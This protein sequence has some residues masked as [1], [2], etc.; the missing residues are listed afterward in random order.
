MV[1]RGCA[2]SPSEVERH[3]KLDPLAPVMVDYNSSNRTQLQE[4]NATRIGFLATNGHAETGSFRLCSLPRN[5]A[6]CYLRTVTARLRFSFVLPR[7]GLYG[8]ASDL[9]PGGIG[10]LRATTYS[11]L[12]GCVRLLMRA[13]S[14]RCRRSSQPRPHCQKGGSISLQ[15]YVGGRCHGQGTTRNRNT[16]ALIRIPRCLAA[17]CEPERNSGKSNI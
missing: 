4:H 15:P 2:Q 7:F 10:H 9:H 1:Y 14:A 13:L 16:P 8:S 17:V 3:A 5:A 11:G 6:L 12:E